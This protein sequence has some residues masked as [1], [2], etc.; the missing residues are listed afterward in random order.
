MPVE[1][2]RLEQGQKAIGGWSYL[3][4]SAAESQH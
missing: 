1:N 4:I 2:K 3:N